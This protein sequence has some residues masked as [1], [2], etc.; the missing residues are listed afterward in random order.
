M[1]TQLFEGVPKS[2]RIFLQ[3]GFTVNK[4]IIETN[5]AAQYFKINYNQ[6]IYILRV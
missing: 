3:M 6:L 4:F 1:F 5:Q 2:T